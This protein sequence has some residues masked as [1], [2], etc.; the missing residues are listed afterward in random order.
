MPALRGMVYTVKVFLSGTD[1]LKNYPDELK[2]AKYQLATFYTIKD[3]MIPIL[4]DCTE[5]LLDSGAFSM[6]NGRKNKID[7]DSYLER[8]I[9]FIK[10][11]NVKLFFELDLDSVIG[12]EKTKEFTK[13]LE[14]KTGR[15]CIP[16]W[17]KNRGVAE[18]VRLSKEYK[19]IAVG[20]FAIK[21]IDKKQYIGIPPMIRKAHENGCRVHGLGFTSTSYYNE[22]RF[23]TVDSTTW[24]VG[25]KYG[26]IAYLTNDNQMR[27]TH[28]GKRVINQRD[29]MIHNWN[30]WVKYQQYADT[31]L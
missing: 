11:Y 15:Q 20:G 2:K 23:D 27:Q 25:G 17:H 19:Y 4:N 29:L 28:N 1:L 12:Y 13:R 26:N 6:M 5:W 21:E 3:W 7:F 16:V 31:H 18:W 22:I 24:N 14:S 9:D 8:Y 30:Q 10:S